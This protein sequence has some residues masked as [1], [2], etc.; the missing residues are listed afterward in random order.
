[1]KLK[2]ITTLFAGVAVLASFCT[3]SFAQ[4]RARLF[5]PPKLELK[6]RASLVGHPGQVVYL[7]ISRNGDRL[8]TG[9]YIESGTTLWNVETG[10]R[11]AA[12]AG[13]A[14]QFSPDG[15]VLLTITKKT[16]ALW[17]AVTGAPKGPLTGHDGAIT[18]V[19]FSRDGTKLATGSEDGTV[20][21]W[22]LA[23]GQSSQTLRVWRVKKLPKFRFISRMLH[24]P[25]KV[26]V[27]FSPDQQSVLT[28]T[29][30]EDSR[31]KVWDVTSGRLQAEMAGPVMT[32]GYDTKEAG[33]TEASFSPDG[34]F[35]V[36]QSDSKVRIWETATHK[37]V[38]EFD[39]LFSLE[40]FSPDSKWLG[41]VSTTQPRGYTT[42]AD[43]GAFLNLETMTLHPTTSPIDIGFLNQQAFSPDG[44]T[45]VIASGY[46]NYHA[47]LIDIATGR[48]TATIP[49]FVNWGFD[50]ISEY[51]K[52][53][54]ILSF[55]PSSKFLMGASHNSIRL[56]DVSTG[57]LAWSTKDASDPAR[58][59][60]DGKL[61]VTVNKDRKTV[62][63]WNVVSE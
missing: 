60:N 14:P 25:V 58:F 32:V 24:V 44:R 1:M 34:K 61:L 13:T 37:L 55:H 29:Y 5:A 28:T 16:V 38:K 6:L 48:V 20:K 36:T 15:R 21:V 56:W 51:Q 42:V 33:V 63:L 50:I 4:E 18:S 57:A 53:A 11:I 17:D 30:W 46:K 59:S 39:S 31:A 12:V 41:L 62:L 47:A 26:Y 19:S 43:G 9:G 40:G 3:P 45:Y 7:A 2:K 22:D 52:E 27:R 8:A 35:I 23:S 49:L 54:D 10:E